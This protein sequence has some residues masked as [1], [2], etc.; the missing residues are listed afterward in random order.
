MFVDKTNRK[1]SNSYSG[2]STF[3]KIR[4]QDNSTN[5]E[6]ITSVGFVNLTNHQRV[7]MTIFRPTSLFLRKK[8][9]VMMKR[10]LLVLRILTFLE[11]T[12]HCHI[13][14]AQLILKQGKLA[15]RLVIRMS[16]VMDRNVAESY[17]YGKQR[18]L[19]YRVVC[20]RA[21]DNH[22]YTRAQH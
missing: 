13:F 2:P 17:Y 15:S 19:E 7:K 9:T 14:P 10:L 8:N 11:T 12:F 20:R 6:E 22:S 4:V 3:R 16:R 1:R 18:C 21:I 5:I